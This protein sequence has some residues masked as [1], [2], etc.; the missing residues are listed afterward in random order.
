[1]SETSPDPAPT[2]A[3][4]PAAGAAHGPAGEPAEGGGA[5]RLGRALRRPWSRGQLIAAALLA[6]VGF[7]AAVQ[8]RSHDQDT[9][10]STASQQDL[11]ALI[12]TQALA[13][14][15]VESEL[16]ELERTRDA[17]Q[18]DANAS[19]AAVEVAQRQADTLGV[20]AG[21]VPAT[22]PGIRATVRDPSGGVGTD[23]LLNGIQELRDAGAEA[24]EIND[25]VRVVAQT[26]IADGRGGLLVGGVPVEPPYVIE[27]I[28]SPQ[29]LES[30]LDFAGG[31][32]TEV[33]RV[34]GTVDVRRVGE[35]E[36][37]SIVESTSQEYAQPVP[38]E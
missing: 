11:V 1:M 22:G 12:N 17:L 6:A 27:A 7:A 24:I 37:D 9:T 10:F 19:R 29:T 34:G 2:R 33:E 21:T 4:Q 20:L 35:V 32:V 38:E 5:D 30:G 36:I 31:F 15:R 16:A 14:D 3:T 28:G 18:D 8:V 25:S 26:G 13:I 23:Q